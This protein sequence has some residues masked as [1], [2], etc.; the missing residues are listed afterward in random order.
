M[1]CQGQVMHRLGL[2]TLR[3]PALRLAASVTHCLVYVCVPEL[4]L[5]LPTLPHCVPLL[6]VN[7]RGRGQSMDVTSLDYIEQF[8]I[9]SYCCCWR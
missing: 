6:S 4:P 3:P 2:A 9:Y 8:V 1:C 5:S 7:L